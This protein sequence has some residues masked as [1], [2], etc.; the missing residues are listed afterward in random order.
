[1]KMSCQVL[2]ICSK[3]VREGTSVAAPFDFSSEPAGS[4]CSF[5]LLS[6]F[7]DC[8]NLVVKICF[9]DEVGVAGHGAFLFWGAI[10]RVQGCNQ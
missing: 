3:D 9:S 7:G 4:F 5:G 10:A 1:M 6:F 8:H 2:L